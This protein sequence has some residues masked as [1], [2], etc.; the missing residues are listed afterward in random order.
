MLACLTAMTLSASPAAAFRAP[1]KTV[2]VSFDY[3]SRVTLEENYRS[4]KRTA[5][6]A[7]RDDGVRGVANYRAERSCRNDLLDKAVKAFGRTELAVYHQSKTG[8]NVAILVAAR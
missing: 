7:C 4:I 5:R 3:D 1:A 8:R 2:E 6:Q